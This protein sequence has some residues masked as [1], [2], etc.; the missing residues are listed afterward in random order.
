ML[1]EAAKG[2][3]AQVVKLLLDWTGSNTSSPSDEISQSSLSQSSM[4]LQQVSS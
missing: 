2:G 3:H 1:I 4:D